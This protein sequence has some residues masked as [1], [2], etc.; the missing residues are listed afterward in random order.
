MPL[1]KIPMLR[2]LNTPIALGRDGISKERFNHS[3]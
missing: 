1:D 3:T 2:L